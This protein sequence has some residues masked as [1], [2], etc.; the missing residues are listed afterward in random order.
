MASVVELRQWF[1]RK[2]VENQRLFYA[3]AYQILGDA[4]EVVGR[5]AA[6]LRKIQTGLGGVVLPADGAPV[7]LFPVAFPVFPPTGKPS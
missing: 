4:H 7:D 5:R 6:P 3:I 1:E 2:V